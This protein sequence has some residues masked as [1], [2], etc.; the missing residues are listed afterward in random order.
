MTTTIHMNVS[1]PEAHKLCHN[2]SAW[3][4]TFDRAKV[5]CKTCLQRLRAQEATE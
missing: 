3:R 2:P 5:T 1:L 4:G